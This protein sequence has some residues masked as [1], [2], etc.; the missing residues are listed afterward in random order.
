MPN[1]YVRY[2]FLSAKDAKCYLKLGIDYTPAYLERFFSNLLFGDKWVLKNRYLHINRSGEWKEQP[3]LKDQEALV[4][5]TSTR[6]VPDK[7]QASSINILQ[8]VKMIG[9]KQLKVK[10]MLQLMN[11]RNRENFMALY[12]SPA[13]SQGYVCMLYP[14]SPRHP[15]QR[16][17]LTVKGLALYSQ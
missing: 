11:L 7:L 14:E 8:L 2:S 12:L 4:A 10:E 13:I 1:L 9:K 5:P 17:Q 3:N 6:Q 16:Y 15:K